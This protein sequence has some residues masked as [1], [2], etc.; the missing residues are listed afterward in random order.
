MWSSI[1]KL[2]FRGAQPSV[3]LHEDVLNAEHFEEKLR[4]KEEAKARLKYCVAQQIETFKALNKFYILHSRSMI[5]NDPSLIVQEKVLIAAKTTAHNERLAASEFCNRPTIEDVLWIVANNGHL[6]LVA[7]LINLS[8]AT[9][10]CKNLQPLIRETTNKKGMTQLHYFCEKG[11]QKS[12]LRMLTMQGIDIEALRFVDGWTCLITAANK[13]HVDICRILVEHGAQ[14]N[15]EFMDESPLHRS[16]VHGHIETVR[17]LC[18][19]GAN[20]EASDFN[21]MRPLHR[22]V[23]SSKLVVVKE[24]VKR[25]ADINART[26]MRMTPLKLARIHGYSSIAY[27]LHSHGGIE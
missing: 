17:F 10:N 23:M 26:A 19:H 2:L 16:S 18:D 8:R 24:L 4:K 11:M 1:T 27:F 12:V 21:G 3:I 5:D 20:I 22:A 6:F 9:R 25:K 7:K 14:L 13:G 15:A